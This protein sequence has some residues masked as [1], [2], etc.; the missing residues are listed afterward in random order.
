MEQN[1][2]KPQTALNKAFRKLKP[3]SAEFVNFTDKLSAL[4]NGIDELE[5]EENQKNLVIEFLKS[6][7]YKSDLYAVNTKG[8]TDLVIHTKAKASSPVGVIIEVKRPANKSEMITKENINKKAFQELI[9]YY[10]R[11]RITQN[12]REVKHLIVTNIYEWFIYDASVIEKIF[13]QNKKFVQLFRDSEE[14]RLSGTGTDFFYNEVAKPA[15]DNYL[16]TISVTHFD[17]RE[18]KPQLKKSVEERGKSTKLISL[19]KILSPHHLLKLPFTNDSNT[20]DRKFYSE[21]LHIIG[22]GERK[23]KGRKLIE[24]KP[25]ADRDSGSL[26]EMTI[27]YLKSRNSLTYMK[28]IGDYGANSEEQLFGVALELVIVWLNRILFLKLLEAQLMGYHNGDNAYRFLNSTKIKDYDDLDHLFFKVLAEPVANRD[29]SVNELFSNVPYLNSSLFELSEIERDTGMNMGNLDNGADIPLTSTTVLKDSRGKKSKGSMNTLEYLF[30][31]LDAYDFSSEGSE[32]ELQEHGKSLINA[33]VLGLIFEKL[34]GYKDGSFFT[35]GYITMYMCRETIR[36]AV[37]TKFSEQEKFSHIKSFEELQDEISYKDSETRSEANDIINS[38]KICDPAVGSGHFL[39]SA[40]NEMIAVKS[41]LNI[42]SYRDGKRVRNYDV[43]VENDELV[44]FDEEDEVLF[45]YKVGEKK[46][47]TETQRLQEMLFHEKQAIIEN[48]LFGVDINPNSVKIC[49][50]RLWIELLKNAYYKEDGGYTQLETL[51]NIDINIKCGNSLISRYD[52]DIVL[53]TAFKGKFTVKEYREA[54]RR[55]QNAESKEEKREMEKLIGSIKKNYSTQIDSNGPKAKKRDALKGEL[56]ALENQTSFLEL[57][58]KQTTAKNRRVREAKKELTLLEKE[59]TLLE[60][61]SIFNHAFE[62]RFEFP[63]VLDDNGKFVGFDAV[64][65][66]PPYIRQEELSDSKGFLQK[67]YMTYAGT[68]DIYVYFVERAISVL[69]DKGEFAYILPNKWLRAGYG[70]ALRNWSKPFYQYSLMDFGDLP[71]FD[72]A[73]TYPLIWEMKKEKSEQEGF[74]AVTVESLPENELKEHVTDSVFSVLKEPLEDSGWT[75]TDSTTQ[76][77]I[78][79]I[80]A[81]GVPLGEYVD[82]KIYRGVLTGLNEAFVIDEETK[83]RLI[84][85]DSKSAKVIKPFLAGRDIKRY[86]EPKSDKYLLFT[87]RGFEIEEYPAVLK[88]LEQFRTQLEPKPKGWKSVNGEKWKGRK[89]GHYKWYE[90]Q[91][92]V[93]YYE[94]FEKQKIMYQVFQVEPCFIYDPEGTYCNN[95]MWILP[96]N[97]LKLLGIL[98]SKMGWFLISKHCTPIQN[99]YQLIWKYLE[100][101]PIPTKPSPEIESLVTTILAKKKADPTADCTVEESEIDELVFEL[102]G[103]SDEEIAIVRGE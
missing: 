52:L 100:Q 98:N 31:F 45:R 88:H 51:P 49:R 11:E 1:I 94:E 96:A 43:T 9:L 17:L 97:D 83:E 4:L 13:V 10:L 34:N 6:T 67:H 30:A 28:N 35:P 65:G 48:C 29:Q 73:T 79:K 37:V 55:Y 7:Y 101:V 64:I 24:R 84:A 44:I 8:R 41:D 61:S 57:T 46:A 70:K 86:Q 87:R 80:K 69:R 50:L 89:T 47:T 102:Y 56:Y 95:S 103:L 78:A 59:I 68:A 81:A 33:S 82:G 20:L 93:D 16:D 27:E 85:E 18:Y 60:S 3:S 15:I 91:D 54:V 77:L 38:L 75:L 76:R 14:T 40:L 92:S 19:F 26:L 58:K 12:N 90:V 72:E 23:E 74:T 99:G 5:H 71:V 22:L 39:V 32:G 21:L 63:E 62:W 2:Q 66:N 42:L 25:E 36:R 53:S